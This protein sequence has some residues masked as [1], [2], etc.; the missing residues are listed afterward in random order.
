MS[1]L[2]QFLFGLDASTNIRSNNMFS[3]TCRTWV[4]LRM[5]LCSIFSLALT[6]Y[7]QVVLSIY[8]HQVDSIP[9]D[10]VD[11]LPPC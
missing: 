6:C 11:K 8:F 10:H 3:A 9:G 4:V 1:S 5:S 7:P 2:R